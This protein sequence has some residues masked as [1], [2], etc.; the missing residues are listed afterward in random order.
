MDHIWSIY[1]HIWSLYRPYMAIYGPNMVHI[2][3]YMVHIWPYMVIDG[4]YMTIYGHIWAIYGHIWAIYGPYGRMQILAVEPVGN[5]VG[6]ILRNLMFSRGYYFFLVNSRQICCIL[7]YLEVA[8][9]IFTRFGQLFRISRVPKCYFSCSFGNVSKIMNLAN[10]V[11]FNFSW[12]PNVP[13][14][15]NYNIF[16]IMSQ[17]KLLFFLMFQSTRSDKTKGN[18]NMW[19]DVFLEIAS[20]C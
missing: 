20:F 2:W 6:T 7:Q 4:P 18:T 8:M 14:Q 9:S 11:L 10:L 19:K 13:A 12:Q 15:R 5:G 3:P 17:M 16:K 1:G